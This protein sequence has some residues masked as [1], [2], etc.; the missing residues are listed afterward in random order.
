VSCVRFSKNHSLAVH[1]SVY[2][3]MMRFDKQERD[4]YALTTDKGD[5][6]GMIQRVGENFA[7]VDARH[8]R[9]GSSELVAVYA[10]ELQ[11]IVDKLRDLEAETSPRR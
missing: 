11:Q 5:H 9:P 1:Q 2:H 10:D 3:P 8:L 7:F 4:K 6:V